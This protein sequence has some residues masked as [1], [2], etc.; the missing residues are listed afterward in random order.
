MSIY[1]HIKRDHI[2]KMELSPEGQTAEKYLSNEPRTGGVGENVTERE[3]FKVVDH[4]IFK[5]RKTPLKFCNAKRDKNCS[6]MY[7]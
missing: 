2:V 7:V 1:V 4:K 5:L 6:K 3:Q